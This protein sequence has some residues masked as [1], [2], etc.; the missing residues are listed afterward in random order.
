[1]KTV[2]RDGPTAIAASVVGTM[3]PTVKPMAD[4]AKD[5][6]V[7]IPQNF[8]N[9]QV[10]NQVSDPAGYTLKAYMTYHVS[11]EAVGRTGNN[12]IARIKITH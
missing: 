3:A 12:S 2:I 7:T 11:N 6:A 10:N 5:S 8:P 4:A 1:M 9:L